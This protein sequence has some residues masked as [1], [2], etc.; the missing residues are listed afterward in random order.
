MEEIWKKHHI[1][2]DK[3]EFSNYGNFR[4]ASDKRELKKTL[5]IDKNNGKE[6]K[7]YITFLKI[8][9]SSERKRF[10]LHRIIA[11]L[12]V[13]NDDVKNKTIVKHIDGNKFNNNSKN[14]IWVTEEESIMIDIVRTTRDNGKF[15]EDEVIKIRTEFEETDINVFDLA[16]KYKATASTLVKLLK[17]E[18]YYNIQPEKKYTYLINNLLGDD[19]NE[20]Y[21]LKLSQKN[22]VIKIKRTTKKPSKKYISKLFLEKEIFQPI[23]EDYI[24]SGLEDFQILQKYNITVG[25][26]THNKK[27]YER[28]S[29]KFLDNEE[30][31]V[32]NEKVYISN[33]GRFLNYDK[34]R[35]V[36]YKIKS[37]KVAKS[38]ARKIGYHFLGLKNH[39]IIEFL[40]GNPYNIKLENLTIKTGL[41]INDEITNKIKEEFINTN[42][43]KKDLSEKYNI[44]ITIIR[45]ILENCV[46]KK[47][48]VVCGTDDPE[49][50][51]CHNKT[52]C[53]DCVENDPKLYKNLTKQERQ[54][55]IKKS[56][57]WAKENNLRIKLLAARSRAK[58][59]GIDF[60]IDEGFILEL[61]EKQQ[62]CCF[63][64]GLPIS[65]DFSEELDV[66]SI[67]RIDSNY[68]YVKNN[69]CLTTKFINNMKLNFTVD[70][71]L[72]YVKKI[73]EHTNLKELSENIA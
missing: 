65:I 32:F 56:S 15:S 34:T 69:V 9:N 21:E 36:N 44:T 41:I 38:I 61:Y 7:G 71:F 60:D 2:D 18:T 68:G 58:A 62:R 51:L 20:F 10:K 57:I 66:F 37:E 1:I 42:I 63:Y 28:P 19:Y 48:C 35:I 49:D 31:I 23:Y 14:L 13:E 67:D 73:Y 46:K 59:K 27:I 11:D 16:S 29:V 3:Y 54:E 52:K 45:K 39:E 22:S 30:F 6:N 55:K 12:F 5:D 17:Y 24:N 33:L 43:T 53:D 64:S 25:Q 4:K 50:F 47:I 8:K 40:D 70:E 72:Y 26:L